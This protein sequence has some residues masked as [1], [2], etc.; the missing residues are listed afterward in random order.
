MTNRNSKDLIETID[1]HLSACDHGMVNIT[2]STL[3]QIREALTPDLP[4][5]VAEVVAFVRREA[6]EINEMECAPFTAKQLSKAADMLERLWQQAETSDRFAEMQENKRN[7]ADDKVEALEQRIAELEE[8][9]PPL[10]E[11]VDLMIKKLTRQMANDRPATIYEREAADMLERLQSQITTYIDVMEDNDRIIAELEQR[12]AELDEKIGGWKALADENEK[13][14]A[15]LE[16]QCDHYKTRLDNYEEIL[17]INASQKEV[18][19]KFLEYAKSINELLEQQPPVGWS[20][21]VG[22]V[23]DY[24]NNQ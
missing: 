17:K 21:I 9:T 23:P 22:R 18:I 6:T 5:D 2:E 16:K 14:I 3:Q 4:E 19:L 12:I 20:E 10:P 13:S 1:L 11:D 24:G 7:E 8:A 15:E